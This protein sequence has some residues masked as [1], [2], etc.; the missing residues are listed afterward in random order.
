[1]LEFSSASSSSVRKSSIKEKAV[2][3]THAHSGATMQRIESSSAYFVKEEV[4]RHGAT[5][6]SYVLYLLQPVHLCTMRYPGSSL[7]AASPSGRAR[8]RWEAPR[9]FSTGR[10][11]PGTQRKAESRVEEMPRPFAHVPAVSYTGRIV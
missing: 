11:A 3:S 9:N 5:A 8:E 2:Q 10:L 7:K 6:L 1:M 4:S